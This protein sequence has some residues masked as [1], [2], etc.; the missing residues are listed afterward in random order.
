MDDSS[1]ASCGLW[2]FP[3]QDRADAVVTIDALNEAFKAALGVAMCLSSGYRN[4]QTQAA[5]G[6]IY[7]WFNLAWA[8]R[9]GGGSFEPWHGE[10]TS[11]VATMDLKMATP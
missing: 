11:A 7:G 1:S 3:Y 8:R 9:G 2:Q 5:L 6:P 4:L 10:L